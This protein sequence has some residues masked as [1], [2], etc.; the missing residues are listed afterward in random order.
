MDKIRCIYGSAIPVRSERLMQ[1]NLHDDGA[2]VHMK[3][4]IFSSS[5]NRKKEGESSFQTK[6]KGFFQKKIEMEFFL[7]K[8][9]NI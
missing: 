7:K 6:N 3:G 9:K 1:Y 4:G 5:G 2:A 8:E